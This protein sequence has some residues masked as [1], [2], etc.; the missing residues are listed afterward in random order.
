MASPT[1]PSPKQKAEQSKYLIKELGSGSFAVVH[2]ALPKAATDEILAEYS[3][4]PKTRSRKAETVSGLRANLQAVKIGVGKGADSIETEV[5]ILQQLGQSSKLPFVVELIDADDSPLKK[6]WYSMPA[7]NGSDLDDLLKLTSGPGAVALPVGLAWHICAQLARALLYLHFGWHEDRR[8]ADW[9]LMSHEDIWAKNILFRSCS[10]AEGNYPNAVLADFGKGWFVSRVH[11]DIES[12]DV[13]LQRQ[14]RDLQAL[15][16]TLTPLG[17]RLKGSGIAK[18][19]LLLD[20]VEQPPKGAKRNK[21][22]YTALR[23]FVSHAEQ[24]RQE[25]YQPL[26][27]ELVAYFD[28]ELV[29]D[30]ELEKAFPV[31]QMAESSESSSSPESRKRKVSPDGSVEGVGVSDRSKRHTECQCVTL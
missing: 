22:A 15:A 8:K 30:T 14:H 25:L 13:A 29:T 26:S 1:S 12:Q 18:A 2:L 3:T 5:R 11:A 7:C 28:R 10:S 9:P 31:L 20:N 4:A 6:Y 27:Q 21:V 17:H 24:R 16:L 23:K 19:L